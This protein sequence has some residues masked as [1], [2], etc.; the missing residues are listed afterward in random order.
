MRYPRNW[1]EKL[2]Q[3]LNDDVIRV[4]STLRALGE[5]QSDI[6]ENQRKL[7]QSIQY[8]EMSIPN[9]R[10]KKAAFAETL[11][12]YDNIRVDMEDQF[13][14]IGQDVPLHL[15]ADLEQRKKDAEAK[16]TSPREMENLLT[17]N[18]N[19]LNTCKHRRYLFA[20]TLALYEQAFWEQQAFH[21]SLLS[22]LEN[23]M[24]KLPYGKKKLQIGVDKESMEERPSRVKKPKIGADKEP[25]E[26]RPSERPASP[27]Y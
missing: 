12:T 23:L 10:Q 19:A 21:D 3:M 2:F 4:K 1:N 15:L 17:S 8:Y 5:A 14:S 13:R 27:S 24:S 16:A 11:A 7:G 22:K 9:I 20:E 18:F 25:M 26:E 6:K